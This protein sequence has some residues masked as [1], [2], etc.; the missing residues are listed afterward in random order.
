MWSRILMGEKT[1]KIRIE[2]PNDRNLTLLKKTIK[3]IIRYGTINFKLKTN[4]YKRNPLNR[5]RKRYLRY[6]DKIL[7]TIPLEILLNAED[8]L[9]SEIFV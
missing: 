2:L 7:R 8:V 3:T 5:L 4:K 9:L 1:V 6:C